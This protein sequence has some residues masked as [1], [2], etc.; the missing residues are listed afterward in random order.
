MPP[1]TDEAGPQQKPL[2]PYLLLSAC[3]RC[4]ALALHCTA[5][6]SERRAISS[7]RAAR[8]PAGSQHSIS[9]RAI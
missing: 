6:I 2:L 8:W 1:H 7:A 9:R 3:S 4:T 5:S